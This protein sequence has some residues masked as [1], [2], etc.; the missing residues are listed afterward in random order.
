MWWKLEID[1]AK[2]LILLR[3][4]EFPL[5]LCSSLH[6]F[7]HKQFK[8]RIEKLIFRAVKFSPA[9]RWV[10]LIGRKTKLLSVSIMRRTVTMLL[11]L[12]DQ[13]VLTS[14]PSTIDVISTASTSGLWCNYVYSVFLLFILCPDLLNI[15]F[16]ECSQCFLVNIIF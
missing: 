7:L 13:S 16:M 1:I 5:Q 3:F 9:T 12:N 4:F 6:L 8:K 14:L 11:M 15:I 10:I 2:S